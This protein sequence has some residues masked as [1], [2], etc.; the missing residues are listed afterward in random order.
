MLYTPNNKGLSFRAFIFHFFPPLIKG[1]ILV[2]TRDISYE[3][4]NPRK[5]LDG[6][7]Y[8]QYTTPDV[9]RDICIPY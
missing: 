2:I 8:R 5:H 3:D 9:I 6:L 7:G 1:S 4:G